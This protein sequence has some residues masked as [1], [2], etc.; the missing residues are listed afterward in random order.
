MK[1]LFFG[2]IACG[3]AG[4]LHFA[5]IAGG[6]QW[7]RYF[8]AGE[9]AALLA[10]QGAIGNTLRTAGI[11]VVLLLFGF[12]AVDI[13]RGG[14]RLPWRRTILA[15]VATVFV[16]RGLLGIPLVLLGTGPYLDELR[17]RMGFVVSTS[18]VA[19]AIGLCYLHGVIRLGRQPAEAPPP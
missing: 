15:G 5:I 7:Y 6:A 18:A 2:G 16:L 10:A 12:Y 1:P 13:A 14:R 3:A 8:G 19:L 9:E 11:A 17:Q 4:L